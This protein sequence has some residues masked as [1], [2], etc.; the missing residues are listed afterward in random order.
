M[1]DFDKKLKYLVD[2]TQ[3]TRNKDS[4]SG[5]IMKVG[6]LRQYIR[7][8]HNDCDNHIT[9]SDLFIKIELL[10]NKEFDSLKD[11]IFGEIRFEILLNELAIDKDKADIEKFCNKLHKYGTIYGLKSLN[12]YN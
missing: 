11:E 7:N 3:I 12:V 10:L 5:N 9:T 2:F 6:L 8:N 4:I 1:I